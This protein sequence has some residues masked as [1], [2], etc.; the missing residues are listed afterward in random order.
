MKSNYLTRFFTF[1]SEL[2][3]GAENSFLDLLCMVVPYA[4]PIIP[5]YLTY[6]HTIDLMNFP[7]WVAFTTAFVVETLGMAS[8]ATAIKFWG[9]NRHYKRIENKAPLGLAVS[10]YV[11][12]VVIVVMVNVILEIVSATR[13][14][15]VITAIGMFSLLSFP[16]SV[17]VAIRAQFREILIAKKEAKENPKQPKEYRPKHASDHRDKILAMLKDEHGKSGRILAPK[18]ITAKLKLDH[19]KSKGYISTLTTQWKSENNIKGPFEI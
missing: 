11:V 13:T 8:V 15:A 3:G 14:G 12:Y 2:I 5:A 6:Q 9:Y 4:V 18:E 16:S 19:D 10:V 1:V 17:L 7:Q